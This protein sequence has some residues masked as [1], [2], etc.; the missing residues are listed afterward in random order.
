MRAMN[1]RAMTSLL[2]AWSIVAALTLVLGS[3]SESSACPFCDGGPSGTNEVKAV[4]FGEDF[5]FNLL[6]TTLPFVALAG[7]VVFL[8]FGPPKARKLAGAE[9]LD[10]LSTGQEQV[11]P[12]MCAS[13]QSPTEVSFFASE[14]VRNGRTL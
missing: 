13:V 2:R 4:I 8:S 11:R 12:S 6:A 1:M 7:V 9:S 10:S 14:G 5:G 3:A